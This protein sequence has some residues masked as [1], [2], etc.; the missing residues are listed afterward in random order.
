VRLLV[1]GIVDEYFGRFLRET[2]RRRAYVVAETE[3][4]TNPPGSN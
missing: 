3:S 1:L 2:M 4:A